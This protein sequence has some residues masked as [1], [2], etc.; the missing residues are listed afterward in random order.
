MK[1]DQKILNAISEAKKVK[2]SDITELNRIAEKHKI[3]GL[4]KNTDDTYIGWTSKI[5]ITA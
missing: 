3:L 2:A 4:L 1:I 5:R